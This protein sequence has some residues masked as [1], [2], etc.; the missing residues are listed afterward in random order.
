MI[1]KLLTLLAF[2]P[3]TLFNKEEKKIR[4]RIVHAVFDLWPN[5]KIDA[6]KAEACRYGL[7]DQTSFWHKILQG[8]FRVK[9]TEWQNAKDKSGNVR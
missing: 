5:S 9:A 7:V 1:R 3:V 2:D 8:V 6:E 4:R